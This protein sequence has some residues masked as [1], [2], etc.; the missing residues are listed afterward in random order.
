MGKRSVITSEEILEQAYQLA[1][2]PGASVAQY[3]FDRCRMRCFGGDGLQLVCEQD[4]TDQR[5]GGYV[6]A[7]SLRR[8]HED[9]CCEP[10]MKQLTEQPMMLRVRAGDDSAA[11]ESSDFISFCEA[12]SQSLKSALKEFRKEFLSDLSALSESDRLSAQKREQQS[13]IHARAGIKQALLSDPRIKQNQLT[14]A[15]APDALAALVWETLIDSARDDMSYDKTL[16][17]LLRATLY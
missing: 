15:L 4:R 9:A 11:S 13:F 17:E 16:F 3:S 8:N 7:A 1:C 2:E 6:L 14:G 10:K 12:L 5:C